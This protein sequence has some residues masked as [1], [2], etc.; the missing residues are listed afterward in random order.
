MKSNLN[1]AFE[2]N[3]ETNVTYINQL[4]KDK[5]HKW[6]KY[7]NCNTDEKNQI[8]LAAY[9]ENCILFD[10]DLP[11]KTEEEI[12]Q[13]YQG[14]KTMLMKRYIPYFYTWFSPKGYHVCTPFKDLDKLDLELKKE[15]KTH[16]V[17]LFNSDPAKISDAGVVSIPGKP[18]FKNNIVYNI[19]EHN[20][21]INIIHPD[22]LNRCKKNIEKE[23]KIS[24]R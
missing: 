10:R 12:I 9:P 20:K 18:H 6:K 24:K 19:L 5:W 13:D 23:K 8:N 15:I 14:F 16:Y 7:K 21:G 22:I 4:T 11:G 2:I 1:K 3:E 17:S